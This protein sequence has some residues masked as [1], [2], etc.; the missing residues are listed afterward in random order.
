MTRFTRDEAARRCGCDRAW[1]D[2]LIELGILTPDAEDRVSIG[3]LR[4]AQ[5]AR[6]L[7]LAGIGPE[8]LASGIGKGILTL[9]FLDSPIFERFATYGDESFREVAKRTGLELSLVTLIREASGAAT[10]DPDD[11]MREDELVILRFIQAQ[12]AAGYQQVSTERWLRVAGDSLRRL[13]E[14]ESDAWRTDLMEPVMRRGGTAQELGAT[15]FK[16]EAE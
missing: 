4:R 7:Q 15:S 9:D 3:D 10:P 6:T 2:R 8:D 11:R 13:A 14:T 16:P 12:F 5:T 1:L